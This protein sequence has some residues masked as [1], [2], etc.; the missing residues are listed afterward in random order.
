MTPESDSIGEIIERPVDQVAIER[1]TSADKSVTLSAVMNQ[2]YCTFVFF[3]GSTRQ[4]ISIG[5]A[6]ET[7]TGG[8]RIANIKWPEEDDL[9]FELKKRPFLADWMFRDNGNVENR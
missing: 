1:T 3:V 7:E 9:C 2:L 8:T 5:R 4:Y 6:G